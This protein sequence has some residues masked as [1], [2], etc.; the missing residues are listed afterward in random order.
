MDFDFSAEEQAFRDE[1]RSFIAANKP[2]NDP[3]TA[4]ETKAWH[5]KLAEKRWIGFS[6]PREFGGSGGSLIE[7]FILKEEMGA[8][9]AP[10]LG[11]DFMGLT[12]VGPS[13]IK[14]GTKEQ[15]EKFLPQ[16]LSGDSCWCTG[17]SEPDYGSDL[18]GLQTRA[19]LDGDHYVINGS[20]IW[21]TLAH[22]AEHCFLLAR[23]DPE[24]KKYRGLTCILT[25]M[26]TPGIEVQAIPNLYGKHSFNQVFFNDVRVPVE[27]R[28]GKEGQGWLVVMNALAHER[29][30]ISEATEKIQHLED[31]IGLARK[32]QKNGRPALEDTSTR[33]RLARFQSQISA[34][35]LNG[36]RYLT[37]QLRGGD[38]GTETSVNKVLRGR[39]EFEMSDVALGL[40]GAGA[41]EAGPWQQRSLDFHGSVI[42]GGSPNIQRNIIGE[43]VLGLPKD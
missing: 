28:L 31:L 18:G 34:M 12:W 43:R 32:N 29:S 11:T 26:N 14:Y 42:G 30:G 36:M 39:L 1:V 16:L 15:Q 10:P 37:K 25:P 20:K 5:A 13:V 24:A 38:P 7:Q 23:S 22:E 40:L 33:R 41:Q 21:T 35:R 17:Y 2:A 4:E 9:K 3:A 19:V 8:A 6:W 27:N